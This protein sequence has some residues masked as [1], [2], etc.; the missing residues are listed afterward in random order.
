MRSGDLLLLRGD[1]IVELFRGREAEIVAAVKAAYLTQ[2]QGDV[3]MP[4]C[5]FLRFP[6]NDTD[7]IIPKPAFLGGDFQI[8]GLKWIASFPTNLSRGM[9][10]ASATLILNSTES[11][12]PEAIMESSV[13]SAYRTAASA[14]LSADLFRGSLPASTVGVIGCGLINFETLRFLL[15]LRPEIQTILL[16]DLNG[17]RALQYRRKCE[18]ICGGREILILETGDRL[19]GRADI[20]SIA[21]TATTPHLE[22]ISPC[23]A[24]DVI[25]HISLRDFNPRAVLAADNVVDDV[26]HVCSNRTSLDLTA[27]QQGNRDFIRATIGA[28]LSGKQPPRADAKPVIFSPFGLGILDLALAHLANR[29]AC[30]ESVGLVI[31]NFLPTTWT[32]RRY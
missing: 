9:E 16:F 18:D 29:L 17:E 20:I 12:V 3:S 2:E 19:F 10:R 26:D 1:E 13:I 27:R 7:R 22:S 30:E 4:N 14:A 11:G 5:A 32:A 6:E 31:G 25:L 15:K 23:R 28:I 21:T 24:D 8:A